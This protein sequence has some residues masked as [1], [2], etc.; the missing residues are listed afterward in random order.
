MGTCQKGIGTIP[1]EC[2][3]AKARRIRES[4][5]MQKVSEKVNK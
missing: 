4:A 1:K 5:L 2:P 3:M